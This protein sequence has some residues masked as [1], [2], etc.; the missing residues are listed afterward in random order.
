MTLTARIL[1]QPAPKMPAALLGILGLMALLVGLGTGLYPRP[2]SAPDA[3]PLVA[4][5][6]PAANAGSLATNDTSDA[7][8]IG[9]GADSCTAP[10]RHGTSSLVICWQAYRLLNEEDELNDYYGLEVTATLHADG[11]GASWAA[12]RAHPTS[13]TWWPRSSQGQTDFGPGT[14]GLITLDSGLVGPTR[15]VVACEHWSSG[16]TTDDGQATW[17]CGL[18][19]W[20]VAGDRDL[21]FVQ[22]LTVPNGVVPTW[23]LSADF[24]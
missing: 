24:G 23:E 1:Y 7:S 21:A 12:I 2:A 17:N 8:G 5:I 6:A 20:G 19:P 10:V 18:C 16:S 9:G 11:T 13:G 14:C 4:T 15:S 22:Q 3:M